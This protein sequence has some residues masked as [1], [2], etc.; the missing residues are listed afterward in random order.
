MP[1]TA[2]LIAEVPG[3]DSSHRLNGIAYLYVRLQ[4]SQEVFA[5]GIP[6]ISA[7]VRG[8]K[9]YDPRDGSTAYST[10]AALCVRDYLAS[11]Y[12][13]ECSADEI[14]DDYFEAAA[15][16]SCSMPDCLQYCCVNS[17]RSKSQCRSGV[18]SPYWRSPG[19]ACGSSTDECHQD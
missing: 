8:K 13:F 6:N 18:C 3:W 9:L 15:N 7:V 14:N 1:I 5:Q 4:Y 19:V 17:A 2:D 16:A 10:N 12:G 11:D